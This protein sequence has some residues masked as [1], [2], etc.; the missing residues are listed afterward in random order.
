MGVYDVQLASAIKEHNVEATLALLRNVSDVNLQTKQRRTALDAAVQ[1]N[2]IVAAAMLLERDASMNVLPMLKSEQ[3]I[4]QCPMLQA[5]KM[6]ESHEEMQLL[7]LRRLKV[8][9]HTW[10]SPRD[11]AII[12]TIPKFAMQYSTPF[13]FFDA[14]NVGGGANICH[15]AEN[16]ALSPLMH[17]A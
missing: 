12:A 4:R 8:V 1:N 6:G 17:V 7:F 10:L 15:E 9:R 13:V 5:F 2:N 14:M 11:Q 3:T 16:D